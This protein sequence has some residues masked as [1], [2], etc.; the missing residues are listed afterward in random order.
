MLAMAKPE[1]RYC[2]CFICSTRAAARLALNPG[3]QESIRGATRQELEVWKAQVKEHVELTKYHVHSAQGMEHIR[4]GLLPEAEWQ[5][6]DKT[7]GKTNL[8]RRARTTYRFITQGASKVLVTLKQLDR[9]NPNKC[10]IEDEQYTPASTIAAKRNLDES[11]FFEEILRWACDNVLCLCCTR[12][13]TVA[14]A[15]STRLLARTFLRTSLPHRP[16]ATFT[17]ALLLVAPIKTSPTGRQKSHV[18]A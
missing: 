3:Q 7:T 1:Q 5:A 9:Q 8:A 4:N 6:L 2:S 17:A 18:R 12:T 10:N 11:E 13:F 14:R 16:P 15:A